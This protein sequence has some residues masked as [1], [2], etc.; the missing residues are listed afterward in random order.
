MHTHNSAN[1][2][3]QLIGAYTQLKNEQPELALATLVDIQLEW[4]NNSDAEHLIALCYKSL[5]DFTRAKKH[6]QHCLSVDQNQPEVLNNLANLLK[7]QDQLSEAEKHYL[8]ALSLQP[9]YL[10]AQRNLAI[11]YQ[12]KSDYAAAIDAYR[13]TIDLSPN[14]VS[15]ISGNA[16]CLRLIGESVAAQQGYQKA[17]AIDPSNFKSWHNL[18]LN[19]HLQGQLSQA[20][21]CYRKAYAIAPQSPEVTESLA[22][23]LYE[24][25]EVLAAIKLFTLALSA[26]PSNVM[27]HERFNGMLWE[28]EFSD[29]FGDSYVGAIR[30]L[31]DTREMALSYAS[32]LYRAGRV[33]QA[34]CVIADNKLNLSEAHDVLSLRG[35]IAAELGDYSPAYKLLGL[36]LEQHYSK[37]VARQMVK[38]DIVQARYNQ[39]QDLLVTMFSHAPDCQLSWALQSLVWRLSGDARYHW[40][41]DYQQFIQA[42]ELETPKGYTSL[43]DFLLA[44]RA[45]LNSMH[46]NEHEPL[47]Q[48]LRNGTQTAPRLLHSTNPVLQ[49]LKSCLRSIVARYIEGLSDDAEHPLLGRK[50][51]QFQFSGSWSVKLRANGFHVNHVHP[52]GWISSSC[53]ITIPASMGLSDDPDSQRQGHIKFGQ[54]PLQLGDLERVEL[55]LEPKPGMVVLFPSYFWHGTYPFDGG[56]SDFRL[57]APF[58]VV[59]R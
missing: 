17:L 49:Q 34:K 58:D 6:F 37:D 57:T 38:I 20:I 56:K 25:G 54:S 30:R 28:T 21:T 53:Y 46:R 2:Q 41:C 5:G 26:D 13:K 10:D 51:P 12:A 42:Y 3:R 19:F 24:N 45:E 22:L 1:L 33:E 36:S 52:D 55:S 23:T 18:G 15:A 27:L 59:P 11:C 16:D 48:T 39:A 31:T 32:L 43:D 44:I 9:N 50:S 29:Q 40:L 35:Q 4:P 8:Q 14:D 47:Q 7:S